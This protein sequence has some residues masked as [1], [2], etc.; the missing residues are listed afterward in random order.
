MRR[1][2]MSFGVFSNLH[3]H[4]NFCVIL[5][6]CLVHLVI[7][8]TS[9]EH[10]AESKVENHLDIAIGKCPDCFALLGSWS[11]ILEIKIGTGEW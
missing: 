4:I 2:N 1:I 3:S 8:Q 10:P 9:L 6:D 11:Q 5:T 7:P